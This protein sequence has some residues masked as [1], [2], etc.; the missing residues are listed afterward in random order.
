MFWGI[1]KHPAFLM[2][3]TNGQIVFMRQ[4]IV[5]VLFQQMSIQKLRCVKGVIEYLT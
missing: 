5:V 3:K 4:K 1:K 2:P